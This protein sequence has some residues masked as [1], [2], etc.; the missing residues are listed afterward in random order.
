MDTQRSSCAHC[1][2]AVHCTGHKL[3][4]EHCPLAIVLQ[5]S[6]SGNA[7]RSYDTLFHFTIL[8][9]GVPAE[10]KREMALC[11]HMRVSRPSGLSAGHCWLLTLVIAETH[12]HRKMS[13]SYSEWIRQTTPYDSPWTLVFLCQKSQRYSNEITSTGAPNKGG[14]GS[15]RRFST[16]ISLYLSNGAKY[17]HTCYGRHSIEWRYFQWSSW[18]TP[19]YPKR[20][21]FLH[22]ATPLYFRNGWSWA[23]KIWWVGLS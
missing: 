4:T 22:F 15:S 19:S 20:P 12:R 16:N 3:H 9:N 1:P 5:T 6:D 17:G 7:W 13:K 8:F 2:A 14:V 18:V 11:R 10:P 21:H 23:L